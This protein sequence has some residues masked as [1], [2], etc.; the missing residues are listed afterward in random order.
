M[1]M[2]V[3]YIN[4]VVELLLSATRGLSISPGTRNAKSNE[5]IAITNAK[6]V[7]LPI[8]DKKFSIFPLIRISTNTANAKETYINMMAQALRTRIRNINLPL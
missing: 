6:N 4:R 3:I 7:S 8:A 1:A 5:N 2:I